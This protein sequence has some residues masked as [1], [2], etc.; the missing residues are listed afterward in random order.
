MKTEVE[1]WLTELPPLDGDD[2]ERNTGDEVDDD[3]LPEVLDSSLDDAAA[4]DLDVDIGVEIPDDEPGADGAKARAA[5]A[6]DERW[7]ADVGEPELD[8]VDDEPVAGAEGEPP[9]GGGDFD[10]HEDL[11]P[12]DDDDGEEGTSDPIEHSL[13]EELPA[14]DADDEGDFEDALLLEGR[15]VAPDVES[16]RWADAAWSESS[17]LNTAFS[18]AANENDPLVAVSMLSALDVLVAL[19]RSGALWVSRDGGKTATRARG[20]YESHGEPPFASLAASVSGKTALWIGHATGQL[21]VS[22]DLGESFQAC[23]GVGWPLVALAT[24]EDGSV[25]AL[26]RKG[27]ALELLTSA[28]GTTWFSERVSGDVAALASPN[29]SRARWMACRGAAVA[30]GDNLG[31]LIS[32][33]GKH[34]VRIPGT[35]GATAGTFAGADGRAPLMLAGALGDD[36]ELHL[37]RVAAGASAEIVGEIAPGTALG[38]TGRGAVALGLAWLEE[39]GAVRVLLFDGSVVWGPRSVTPPK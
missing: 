1:D 39:R 7:E 4:E 5:E 38:E 19:A 32:R 21:T 12:S 26:V 15:E 8:L 14:M 33:D 9:A 11:P 25:V 35:A 6:A 17:S 22:R 30:V 28:D 34:F 27:V 36:D 23:P 10:D 3:P 31:A 29:V 2:D 18:W 20:A 37:V 16:L 24:R 13:D